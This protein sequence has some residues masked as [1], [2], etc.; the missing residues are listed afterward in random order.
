VVE[1]QVHSLGAKFVKIDLGETGQTRDGYATELTE[2]QK[3]QQQA[4]MAK[5][6]AQSDIVITTA[7][8][9]G[10]KAPVIVTREMVAA[11]KPGSVVVDLAAETGGNVEGV[12]AGVEQDMNGVRLIGA[13]NFA[14]RVPAHASQMYGANVVNLVTH[15]WDA[16]AKTLRLNLEDEIMKGCLIIHAGELRNELIKKARQG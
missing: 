3:E 7:Q 9:F 6:I 8:V 4:A 14:G 15:F 10:R 12:K 2:E 5:V 1:E 11:M 13:E 16:E